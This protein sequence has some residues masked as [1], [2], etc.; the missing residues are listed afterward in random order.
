MSSRSGGGAILFIS[1][2][3]AL[4]SRSPSTTATRTRTR[5]KTTTKFVLLQR[6][7][8]HHQNHHRKEMGNRATRTARTR[9]GCSTMRASATNETDLQSDDDD[10]AVINERRKAKVLVVGAG[11]SGL[12][13]AKELR[14]RGHEVRVFET[15]SNLGGVW[16]HAT[17]NNENKTTKT[18]MYDSLRTNLPRE[19]MG[20]EA[21]PFL[22]S[23]SSS[24]SVDARRFCSHKEVQGYLQEF[25]KNF[26]LFDVLEFNTTVK[27]CRKKRDGEEIL[28]EREEEFGPKW[29]VKYEQGEKKELKRDT[30][31]A[32]VVANGHYSKPRSARFL[33]ADVFPGKQMHSSTYKEPS[34]FTNQN[35]VLIGAQASGEDISRDIATKAKSVYLSAKT[36]Q[37]AEWGSNPNISE[38]LFRKPN[39]KALL[40]NGSV[41]FED[42][43]V[44]EN[45]DAIVYCIGY[46]YDFPFLDP[47]DANFS[48]DDNYVNPLYEHLFVP[49][50]RSSL[51]FVGL[52]WKVVPFP[53]F[54]LQAKWIAK[55]LSGEL[56]LPPTKEMKI[57]VE[58]FENDRKSQNIP[59]RHWHCL[60]AEQ[61][62]YNDRIAEYAKETK[63]K[64]WRWEM[65]EK[66]GINKRTNPEKYREEHNDGEVLEKAMNEE[67]TMMMMSISSEGTR[68]GDSQVVNALAKENGKEKNE[69]SSDPPL[70][71]SE[72][73]IVESQLNALSDSQ[74]KQVKIY[75]SLLLEWNQKMNLTG[76]KTE[77]DVLERHVADSLSIIE[78]IE[79]TCP[80]SKDTSKPFKIIDVGTGA[81]F[82]GMVL[83]IARPHWEI[84]L[85]DSLQKRTKF[86]D[87]VADSA[88]IKNVKTIW[89]RAEDAGKFESEHRE[90]FDV[91]TA[92]AVADLRLLSELC[93]PFVKVGGAWIA[94]KNQSG[95]EEIESASKAVEI[96]GGEAMSYQEV[97]SIGPDG[98]LR[99][100]VTSYKL[101][102]TDKKY[103]RRAGTPQKKPL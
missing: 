103:P 29:T 89:S 65:Y 78:A 24:S 1:S 76:A 51:S 19:V 96:L 27:E 101:T 73:E 54:E 11:A 36:W 2:S 50:N 67:L 77:N 95:L 87:H 20:Y 9:T 82:P 56:K 69:A 68:R 17:A 62:A 14:Q 4:F 58:N 18:A 25:A 102:E 85:L 93:I 60:G 100:V 33:G 64:E 57:H 16:L 23:S 94:M 47:K 28:A 44:V 71:A 5:T 79:N 46:E 7:C 63:L 26:R 31:D 45:V 3:G 32:I 37:N 39:V 59:K 86:L 30:F 41:E 70:S 55:L 88:G 15:K 83:A 48:V 49:E 40:E 53:Q 66:T 61:F 84:S 10:S 12:V 92:R 21:F 52:C 91:A 98:N 80:N 34:V 99:T 74:M 97:Q 38:N 35:V 13:C 75:S 43:S 22:S 90:Q 81:G 42:G 72:R 6:C 8:F